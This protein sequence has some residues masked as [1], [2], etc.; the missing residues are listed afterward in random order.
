MF[1]V[2]GGMLC[3]GDKPSIITITT[4]TITIII[5]IIKLK[6]LGSS[7]NPGPNRCL[8]GF[9]RPVNQSIDQWIK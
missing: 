7:N 4:I 8:H 3:K 1:A 5:I 6:Q 2:V 9:F